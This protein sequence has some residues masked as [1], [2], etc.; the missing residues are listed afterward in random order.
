MNGLLIKNG[1]TEPFA[2]IIPD[3]N[4]LTCLLQLLNFEFLS[5]NVKQLTYF[6]ND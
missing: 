2:A 6:E 4:Y 1:E 5:R 3:L